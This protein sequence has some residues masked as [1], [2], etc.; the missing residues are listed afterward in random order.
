ML[1]QTLQNKQQHIIIEIYINRTPS[2]PQ[3]KSQ[4][5]IELRL[6]IRVNVYC[7][8]TSNSRKGMSQNYTK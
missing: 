1:P 8:N 3:I 2:T 4:P 7:W 6:D 5:D